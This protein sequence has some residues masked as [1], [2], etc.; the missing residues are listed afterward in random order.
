MKDKHVVEV[1]STTC[2]GRGLKLWTFLSDTTTPT[3]S[4]TCLV[5]LLMHQKLPGNSGYVAMK[6]TKKGQDW[7]IVDRVRDKHY[8]EWIRESDIYVPYSD[9]NPLK[10]TKDQPINHKPDPSLYAMPVSRSVD[11]P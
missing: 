11:V 8:A 7:G 5:Q 2:F 1:H 6:T 4:E 3:A 9:D 10:A